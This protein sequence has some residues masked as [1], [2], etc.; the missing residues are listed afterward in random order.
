MDFFRRL[1][2]KIIYGIAKAHSFILDGLVYVIETG[3]LLSKSFMRGCAL[4]ISMGG[5][6]AVLLLVGPVGSWLFQHPAAQTIL[7]LIIVFP[8]LGA[9]SVSYLKYFKE[10]STQYLFNLSQYLEDPQSVPYRPYRYYKQAYRKAEEEA[11][12]REQARREQQQREWEER[13]RQWHQQQSGPWQQGKWAA[14]NPYEDFIKKYEKSCEILGVPTTAD[15]NK[16]KL[17]YRRKAKAYHPDV[18]KSPD[19]TQKFQEINEA[20]EFLN[21]DNIQRY[22]NLTRKQS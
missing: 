13:F 10:V 9:A 17:A 18:N 6:L 8:I 16:I 11:A 20:Y 12:R 14:S 5:C 21:E 19:A 3:V 7:L 15:L 1:L 2:S 4:L 22:Q